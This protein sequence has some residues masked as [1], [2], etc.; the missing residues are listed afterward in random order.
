M[1]VCELMCPCDCP[2][3]SKKQSANDIILGEVPVLKLSKQLS[4]CFRSNA[5]P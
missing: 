5:A 2:S 1:Q 4:V 3:L